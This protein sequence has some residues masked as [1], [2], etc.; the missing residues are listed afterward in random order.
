MNTLKADLVNDGFVGGETGAVRPTTENIHNVEIT[1]T[2][3]NGQTVTLDAANMLDLVHVGSYNSNAHLTIQDITT[4]TSSGAVRNTDSITFR[5]DHTSNNNSVGEA[6]NF[7]AYF[8]ENYLLAGR[9]DDTSCVQYEVMNQDAFDLIQAGHTGIELLD[10]VRVE[11]LSFDLNDER[12]DL[13]NDLVEENDTGT[14]IRTHQDLADAINA[15]LEAR[16][17]DGQVSAQVRGTFQERTGVDSGDQRSAPIVEL[18]GQPGVELAVNENFIYLA[19]SDEN[20]VTDEGVEVRNSNRY[21]R[22][23][24]QR[25][26]GFD[27]LVATHPV[28]RSCDSQ[29]SFPVRSAPVIPLADPFEHSRP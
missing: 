13:Q 5:V 18:V 7:T 19:P 21:D 14:V 26:E 9:V 24:Q 28:M 11:R 6:S 10:G 20:P 17:L 22:A 8:D 15:A 23:G 27:E 25:E 2:T 16:G 4:K 29:S 3:G 12:I 1:A